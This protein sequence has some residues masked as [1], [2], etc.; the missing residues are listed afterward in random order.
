MYTTKSPPQQ[1]SQPPQLF[2]SV[3]NTRIPGIKKRRASCDARRFLNHNI[4]G[5]NHRDVGACCDF[6]ELGDLVEVQVA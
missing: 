5:L 3:T 4:L 1:S 2:I 6:A